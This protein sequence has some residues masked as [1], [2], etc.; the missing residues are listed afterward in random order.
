MKFSGKAGFRINDVEI[1][2]GVY[3]PTVV[4]KSIKGTVI[5]NYYQHQNSDKSTIDNVRITNQL[6]IVANQ[7]LNKHIANLVYIEFQGVKWKV[8]SFDIRP[9]RVVVSLGGVYNEQST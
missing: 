3:E 5:S 2:P 8:E 7:F 6:S 1:E 4:V 9:P